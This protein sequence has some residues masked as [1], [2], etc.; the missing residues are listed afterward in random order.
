[1]VTKQMQLEKDRQQKA[2]DDLKKQYEN[3][4]KAD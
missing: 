4:I 3:K 1:M 2:M